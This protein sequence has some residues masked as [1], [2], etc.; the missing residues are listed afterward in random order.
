M[1]ERAGECRR[2]YPAA[3]YEEAAYPA[4][5]AKAERKAWLYKM[6]NRN[7]TRN[8]KNNNSVLLLTVLI[9]FCIL[10]IIEILYGQA[11]MRVE[12]ERLALEEQNNQ[13]VQEL[14][15]EWNQLKGTPNVGT[16]T[17]AAVGEEKS[18][19]EEPEKTLTNKEESPEQDGKDDG[20]GQDKKDDGD[21]KDDEEKEPEE[22]E[23]EYAMQIVFLGDSILDSDRDY[24][25]VA[26]LIAESCNAKVY[27]M[28]MGGT[29]A[30][31]LP[32]EQY[33]FAKWES[34]SLLGVVNAILGNI[35][36]DIFDGYRAGEIL[37]DCDFSKTDYFVIEYGVNDFLSRQIP[38]SRYLADGGTLAV[39]EVHTYAGAL[40]HAVDLLKDHFPDSKIMIVTPHYCQI[41]EGGT[42]I[43]DAYSLNYGYGTLV[44][45]SRCAG[46]V[47]DQNKE[48]K[49]G[50]V[51][52]YNAFENSGIKAETADEYLADGVHLTEAGRRAY[53]D[54]ASRLI[55]VDFYPEE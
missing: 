46:Y 20:G 3:G 21:D 48:D 55:K 23:K 18:D 40:T 15:A 49:D 16:E 44:E 8:G 43:G 17:A 5:D 38:Q 9:G 28:S 7:N 4:A 25:G 47:Y 51:I 37:K 53:A 27:N 10:A 41:F 35:N 29:T 2:A 50:S 31:L 12:K 1:T 45:F 34:R 52:F 22:D 33:N 32:N 30:A 11:Q 42:F 19:G 14:K 13:A 26:G 24:N 6:D 39:D 54:Y 36:T